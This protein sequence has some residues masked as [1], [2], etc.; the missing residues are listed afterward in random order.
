MSNQKIDGRIVIDI[1]E[2]RKRQFKGKLYLTGETMTDWI[3]K[4][5]DKFIKGSEV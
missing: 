1:G 4:V 3:K 2:Q 5:I